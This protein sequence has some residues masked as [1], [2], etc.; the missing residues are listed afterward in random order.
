MND[1]K[2]FQPR[3]AFEILACLNSGKPLISKVQK[4]RGCGV[5]M[6]VIVMW[7]THI[8]ITTI[9]TPVTGDWLSADPI[10]GTVGQGVS[11]PKRLYPKVCESI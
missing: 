6:V 8:T 1:I 10:P 2:H 3:F 11:F 4:V 7:V 9:S 5:D